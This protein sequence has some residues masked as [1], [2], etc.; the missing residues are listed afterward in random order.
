MRNSQI[1]K[2]RGKKEEM[3]FI[4]TECGVQY[5]KQQIIDNRRLLGMQKQFYMQEKE[6]V[7]VC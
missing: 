5:V 7:C 2:C 6:I 1:K 3:Y 4:Y